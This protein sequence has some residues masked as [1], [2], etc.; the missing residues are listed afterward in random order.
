MVAASGAWFGPA[1]AGAMLTTV[2][3]ESP[4]AITMNE[5]ALAMAQSG[6]RRRAFECIRNGACHGCQSAEVPA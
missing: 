3:M 2:K 1:S 4:G 6:V 5:D